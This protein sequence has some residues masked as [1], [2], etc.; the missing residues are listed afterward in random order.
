MTLLL[1]L[2]LAHLL[3]D[4]L[5]QPSVW[6]KAKEDR[7]IR[8]YQLYLHI[9]IHFALIMILVWDWTFWPWAVLIA[10]SHLLIDSL[11]IYLQQENRARFLFFAD[12]FLHLLVL[13]LVWYWR[14]GHLF[15]THAVDIHSSLLWISTIL[16]LT[17][18]LSVAI[19]IFISKWTPYKEDKE[20]DSLEDAGKYI[21]Y[22]ERLLIFIFIISNHW[23]AVG[24]LITAKSVFRFGDLKESKERK[25]T[26]YVLIGTLLSFGTAICISLLFQYATRSLF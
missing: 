16:I 3:G 23:E 20:N 17:K 19:K 22:L 26:E 6:V 14:D 18:P 15:S 2:I 12:Q 11:K 24:F 21:G 25:L 1:K 10:G 9:L 4:F 5:L 13:A 8:A 7:K